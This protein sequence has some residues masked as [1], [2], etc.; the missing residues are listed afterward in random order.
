ME[1]IIGESQALIQ[2]LKEEYDTYR[3]EKGENDKITNEQLEKLR[4]DVVRM[5]T[6]NAKLASTVEY[7]NERAKIYAAN[8]E[9]YKKNIAVLDEKNKQY[10][11]TIL[12]HEQS[13]ETLKVKERKTF[14]NIHIFIILCTYIYFIFCGRDQ[15]IRKFA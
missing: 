9:T 2:K 12:K 5:R 3:K 11:V 13:I 4:D 14:I 6:E 1:K 15:I 8:L 7:N 10:Q